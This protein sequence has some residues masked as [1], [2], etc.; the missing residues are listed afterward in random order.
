MTN[1]APLQSF[2]C[3]GEPGDIA[4]RWPIWKRAF[5]IF[6]NASSIKSQEIKF[7][8]LLYSGGMKLQE[9]FYNISENEVSGDSDN[10]KYDTAITKLDQYFVPT[11]QT[12][13]LYER[14]IFRKI[15]QEQREKIEDFLFKLT[16]QAAKC[17]FKEQNEHI[18]DQIV[19]KC[20]ML[21]LR[22]A[23]LLINHDNINV[24]DILKQAIAIETVNTLT[25]R[26]GIKNNNDHKQI[27]SLKASKRNKKNCKR[28]G[29]IN[30]TENNI[31]CPAR[32]SRCDKCKFFG[33]Y[34]ELCLTTKKTIKNIT[35]KNT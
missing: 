17:K 3:D 23:I 22:K 19:E 25:K 21:D 29:S 4:L 16:K 34:K 33:H 28:C 11:Q 30:H 9:I 35:K 18:I 12:N 31:H 20:N 5:E 24:N 6:L 15:H 8:T 7:A 32:H 13:V 2:H 26:T 14:Y 1:P 10:N 27:K